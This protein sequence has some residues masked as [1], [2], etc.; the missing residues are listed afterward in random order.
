[1]IIRP[2]TGLSAVIG[3]QKDTKTNTMTQ[4]YKEQMKRLGIDLRYLQITSDSNLVNI[5]KK[6]S[7][8]V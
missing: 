6:P 8:A 4:Q 3:Q 7:V 2:L 1:M 5:F